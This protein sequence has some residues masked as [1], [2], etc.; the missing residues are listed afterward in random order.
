M[1]GVPAALVIGAAI[2]FGLARMLGGR[3][4]RR[5]SAI[6]RLHAAEETT[7]RWTTLSNWEERLDEREK[8]VDQREKENA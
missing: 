1:T 6:D 3:R 7:A 4:Y 8:E 5:L 2:G